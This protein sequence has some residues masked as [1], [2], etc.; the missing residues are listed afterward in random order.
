MMQG[1]SIQAKERGFNFVFIGKKEA[2]KKGP[3]PVWNRPH[4][5]DKF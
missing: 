3:I 2:S 4:L 1:Q 5:F